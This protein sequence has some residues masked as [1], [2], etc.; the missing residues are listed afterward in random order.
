MAARRTLVLLLLAAAALTALAL[1]A[2]S[3][4]HPERPSSFPDFRKGKVPVYR[5]R[6]PSLV[7][8]KPDSRKRILRLPSKKL[9][10][11]NLKLL[12]RCRY[13]HVQ[14]AVD[15]ARSGDRIL[16]LPG[17]YREEP[18][19][20]AP[21]PDP[22]CKDMYVEPES[23]EAGSGAMLLD[24]GGLQKPA[25]AHSYDYEYTCP[26]DG[27]LIA[28]MG[29]DPKDPD[30][31]CD[32]KCNLQIEGTARRRD[33]WIKGNGTKLNLIKADRADGI[34]LKGFSTE[35]SDFNNIYVLET[36]G[37][38]F[39]DIF[40]D[41]SRE[42]GFLS[43]ASD[44]GLY[45]NL[46]ATHA[47]DSGIYPGS[48][49]EGHCQRY[50]IEI[51]NVDSHHNALGSSG[52]AGNGT[53]IHDSR[54]HHNSIGMV[55][56][57][58]APGH[59]GQPQDCSKV[60]NN[61]IYSNNQDYFNA[62]R[63]EYC[64]KPWLERDPTKTCPTFQVPVGTGILFAGGNG[65]IVRGNRIWD[66]WRGAFELFYV[67]ATFRG[68]N[69]PTMTFDTSNRNQY[70]GN[71]LGYDPSGNVDHNGRM[72]LWDEEGQGNCWSDNK[73]AP[74]PSAE[75]DPATLPACPNDGPFSPGNPVK[76]LSHA[77]CATWNPNDNTDPPGCDWFVLPPEPK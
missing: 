29:D 47:G 10:T 70:T 64:K 1:P 18:S 21:S 66:N 24:S 57:S 49:P 44:N 75:S 43:F 9:R 5:S 76:L 53:W 65:N 30:R 61:L 2:A 35:Y 62:E 3:P 45:E 32:Q 17:I 48:G 72:V 41:K 51:R 26:N 55:M 12:K 37:F 7:V 20:K 27:N 63:D 33:V 4:A 67:P 34:F 40:T 56:D 71:V 39:D 38:R 60:E 31:E 59:P 15:A 28:I 74:G 25:R 11:K 50:G 77:S 46:E 54:F 14:Q 16:L 6:G 23:P 19:L 68:E 69:D 73:V 42:Y 8:C 36:N 52:T 58:F 13:R 22:R